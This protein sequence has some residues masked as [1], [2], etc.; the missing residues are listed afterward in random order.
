M[1]KKYGIRF[2]IDVFYQR[3]IVNNSIGSNDTELL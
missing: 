2:L 3:V 1:L